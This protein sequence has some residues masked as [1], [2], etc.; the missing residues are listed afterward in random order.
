M[1]EHVLNVCRHDTQCAT[2]YHY[3]NF[4]DNSQ[5]HC[6]DLIASFVDQMLRQA[7]FVPET[8]EQLYDGRNR[9][10]HASR[11]TELLMEP[12]KELMSSFK[13]VFLLVDALDEFAGSET[14]E[15][16]DILSTIMEWGVPSLHVLVTSQFHRI[17]IRAPLETLAPPNYR[18]DLAKASLHIQDDI[19]TH[20][21]KSL[22]ES[23][24]FCQ[25]WVGDTGYI[26]LEIEDALSKKSEGSYVNPYTSFNL[27]SQD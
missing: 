25:R 17:D 23:P 16:M 14:E 20:I 18:L 1:L 2:A 15:L 11:C 12:L 9:D 4:R 27:A 10:P 26:L 8:L 22:E 6:G 19:R 24:K 13:E 7:S 5:L 21:N 3:C